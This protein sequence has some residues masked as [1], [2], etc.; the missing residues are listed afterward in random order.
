MIGSTLTS[1][2]VKVPTT[3]GGG[4]TIGVTATYNSGC[5]AKNNLVVTVLSVAPAAPKIEWNSS[6]SDYTYF[7]CGEWFICPHDGEAQMT[8]LVKAGTRSLTWEI[9]APW[10][11]GGGG[12]SVTI[13]VNITNDQYVSSPYIEADCNTE[14]GGV[15]RVK[16]SNC[17]GTSAYSSQVFNREYKSRCAGAGCGHVC[18]NPSNEACLPLSESKCKGPFPKIVSSSNTGIIAEDE[19]QVAEHINPITGF[20]IFPNPAHEQLT[21]VSSN[22]IKAWKMIDLS[23]R[24]LSQQQDIDVNEVRIDI[25]H[26]PQGLYFIEA[27]LGNQKMM[28]K[29][30]V[31][32]D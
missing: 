20:S 25:S 1:L 28:K 29:I 30:V 18:Y 5:L 23:G 31:S 15:L 11:F 17:L 22:N 8:A 10:R 4:G 3:G 32:H 26:V 2:V 27:N 16:A 7:H 6:T 12:Q 9:D 13:P 24:M 21:I 19:L 14:V